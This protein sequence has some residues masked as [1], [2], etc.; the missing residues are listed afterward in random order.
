MTKKKT[1][2]DPQTGESPRLAGL[3]GLFDASVEHQYTEI[4]YIMI[5]PEFQRTH[6]NTNALG[7]LMH[8]CLDLP[9]D[10]AKGELKY[11]PGLGLRRVQWQCHADNAPSVRAAERMGFKLEGIIRWPVYS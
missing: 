11:G 2:V 6:V 3:M 7:L 8:Y 1:S 4:G 9:A 10:L 5:L